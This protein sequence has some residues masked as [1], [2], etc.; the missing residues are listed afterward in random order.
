MNFCLEDDGVDV[1]KTTEPPMTAQIPSDVSCAKIKGLDGADDLESVSVSD[2]NHVKEGHGLKECSS[3]G[4]LGKH[5]EANQV[6]NPT[7]VAHQL[8][9]LGVLLF[10]PPDGFW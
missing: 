6:S 1:Q 5:N 3:G 8:M 7:L 10:P 2:Q 4:Q 9:Q